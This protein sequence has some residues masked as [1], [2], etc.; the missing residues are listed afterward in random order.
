MPCTARLAMS[1]T[2]YRLATTRATGHAERLVHKLDTFTDH[3]RAAQEW[4]PALIWSFYADL[5]AYQADPT[6]RRHRQKRT[7]FD[8]VFDAFLG[9]HTCTELGMAFWDYLGTPL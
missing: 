8:R 9:S 6:A 3:H 2:L 5:K 4:I 7:R 1:P